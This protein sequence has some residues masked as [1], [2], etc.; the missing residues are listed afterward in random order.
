[1]LL[2]ISKKYAQRKTINAEIIEDKDANLNSNDKEI[3][4]TPKIRKNL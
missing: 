3:H 2:F 1:M 4:D